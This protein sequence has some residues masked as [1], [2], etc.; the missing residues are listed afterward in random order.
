MKE[1]RPPHSRVR[2]DP[3]SYTLLCQ[4]VLERDGWRCQYCGRL[5]Q[6]EVHHLRSRAQ[7]GAD[8]ELNLITLCADC[9]NQ[10]HSGP[11]CS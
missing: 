7:L 9:H 11:G 10:L 8:S 5:E 6:L 2:L 1:S 4:R 3:E